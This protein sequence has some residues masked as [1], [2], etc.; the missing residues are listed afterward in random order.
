MFGRTRREKAPPAL[1]GRTPQRR[2]Q[3]RR[4]GDSGVVKRLSQRQQRRGC[5]VEGEGMGYGLHIRPRRDAR[6]DVIPLYVVY[7]FDRR[8]TPGVAFASAAP[9]SSES[10]R[11]RSNSLYTSMYRSGFGEVRFVANTAAMPLAGSTQY[12]LFAAPCASAWLLF[13]LH[14]HLA[15]PTV[16][17]YLHPTSRFPPCGRSTSPS[18]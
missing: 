18:C 5:L 7:R 8:V 17:P 1:P 9:S 4:W 2:R 12:S 6:Q 10:Y 13:H 11:V 15:N 3:Q 16:S 14:F